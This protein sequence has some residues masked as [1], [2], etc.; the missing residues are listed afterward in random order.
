MNQIHFQETGLKVAFCRAVVFQGVQQKGCAL[1]QK[2]VLHE[3]IHNLLRLVKL[4][5]TYI[6]KTYTHI[7]FSVYTKKAWLDRCPGVML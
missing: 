1:L 7:P 6:E 4:E 2:T 5:K 3:H